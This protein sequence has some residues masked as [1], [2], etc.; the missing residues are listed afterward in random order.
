M[1]TRKE[2]PIADW[3]EPV[4]EITQPTTAPPSA[5]QPVSQIALIGAAAIKHLL[6]K[7]SSEVLVVSIKDII[8]QE[9]KRTHEL[10]PKDAVPIEFHKYLQAFLKS[11]ADKLPPLR[12]DAIDHKIQLT[13]TPN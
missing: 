10:D 5:K 1:T 7:P 11:D 12:G 6:K 13:D 4:K 2:P 9:Y 8:D 3:A